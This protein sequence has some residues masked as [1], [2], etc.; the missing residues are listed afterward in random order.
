LHRRAHGVYLL[1]SIQHGSWRATRDDWCSNQRTHVL[2]HVPARALLVHEHNGRN[3]TRN[4]GATNLERAATYCS[5][6]TACWIESWCRTKA[7]GQG[8]TLFAAVTSVISPSSVTCSRRPRQA[9]TD[10][11][12]GWTTDGLEPG[13][14]GEGDQSINSNPTTGVALTMALDANYSLSGTSPGQGALGVFFSLFSLRQGAL[15]TVKL[16]GLF[17]GTIQHNLGPV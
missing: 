1:L 2:D 3:K 10:W 12:L 7:S 6:G 4:A 13:M 17:T 14:V 9:L 11:E 15:S 16:Q 5:S 8:R